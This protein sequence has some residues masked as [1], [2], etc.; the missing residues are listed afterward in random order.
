M[1]FPVALTQHLERSISSVSVYGDKEVRVVIDTANF[2]A[3][4]THVSTT[5]TQFLNPPSFPTG[6][7]M[8]KGSA[9]IIGKDFPYTGG[10]EI[11]LNSSYL[12]LHS[13]DQ[14]RLML[15]TKED[16]SADSQTSYAMRPEVKLKQLELE[17]RGNSSLEVSEKITASIVSIDYDKSSRLV[18][19][20]F[21]NLPQQS[22]GSATSPTPIVGSAVATVVD[23]GSPS[24]RRDRLIFFPDDNAYTFG[25]AFGYAQWNEHPFGG[26]SLQNGA[27]S[28]NGMYFDVH[29]LRKIA[30][31]KHFTL[32]VGLG[33]MY[34]MFIF[35][36]D[37]ITCTSSES[38]QGTTYRFE[39]G[40]PMPNEAGAELT[41]ASQFNITYFTVPIRLRYYAG[42]PDNLWHLGVELTPAV[43][44]GNVL[45]F[46]LRRTGEYTSRKENNEALS[47]E[48][49]QSMSQCLEATRWNLKFT[50]GWRD[51]YVFM[52]T[53]LTPIFRTD[54][55]A[56]RQSFERKL[57]TFSLGLGI[58]L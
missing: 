54:E 11:H 13:Y 58:D 21:A 22:K 50:M 33:I 53:S 49:D 57:H 10:I 41:W 47:A 12:S 17:A 19:G 4:I 14:A 23:Q 42:S 45:S 8:V 20:T 26:L 5:D 51:F 39:Q 36:N 30:A 1:R 34:E 16:R 44:F 15:Q 55:G 52:S 29:W 9:L 35:K 38:E 28:A 31:S 3:V 46:G 32:D 56:N 25:D 37:Y 6:Q 48:R 2:V 24:E 18:T 7:L 40:T 27:Y 43:S